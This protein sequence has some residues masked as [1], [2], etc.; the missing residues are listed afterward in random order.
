MAGLAWRASMQMAGSPVCVSRMCQCR[1]ILPKFRGAGAAAAP[2][3]TAPVLWRVLSP[4]RR[5]PTR[6][7]AT[8]CPEAGAGDGREPTARIAGSTA[9]RADYGAFRLL[10]WRQIQKRQAVGAH[11]VRV[12][13]FELRPALEVDQ[14]GGRVGKAGRRVAECLVALSFDEYRSTSAEA[15][16]ALLSQAEAPT[17][18]EAVA[19]SRSGSRKRTVRCRLPT[20]SRTTPGAAS[21]AQ[22]RKS[23]RIVLAVWYSA[24]FIMASDR[25]VAGYAQVAAHHVDELRIT[26]GGPDGSGVADCPEQQAGYP[27]PQAEPEGGGQ[28]AVQDSDGA[29]APSMR[30][31]SVSERCTGA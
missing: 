19:L 16:S 14:R 25:E 5:L 20:L 18:S 27:P 31:G 10:G 15:R 13:L 12:R 24:R 6:Q 9:K 1:R 2:D 29:G 11:V 3:L 17:N 21:T 30:M 23:A 26:L 8:G 28:R 7:A 4:R 22:G